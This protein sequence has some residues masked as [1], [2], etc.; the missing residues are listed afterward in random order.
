MKKKST[1]KTSQTNWK[2]IAQMRDE[3]IDLSEMPEITAGQ[4]SRAELRIGGKRVTKGKVRVQLALDA[5][6]LAYFKMQ[7]G[8]R[9]YQK[10][11]NDALKAKIREQN[12]ENMIR[13]AIRDE[14]KPVA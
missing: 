8:G 13:R 9:H 10:L 4:M 12:L 2:R 1:S 3:D 7:S 14:L 6:V 5:P 11:I